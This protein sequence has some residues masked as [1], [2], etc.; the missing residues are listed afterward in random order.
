[1]SNSIYIKQYAIIEDQSIKEIIKINLNEISQDKA[2]LILKDF[3][4]NKQIV[5]IKNEI[6]INDGIK[7]INDAFT[8]QKPYDSWIW[9]GDSWNSPKPYP[10]DDNIYVWDENNVNWKI[11]N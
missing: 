2:E 4:P 8:S 6:E 9:V 3:F 7:Y 11:F 5:E 10:K 1:M